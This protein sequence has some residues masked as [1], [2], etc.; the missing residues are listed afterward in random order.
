MFFSDPILAALRNGYTFSGRASRTEFWTFSFFA[1]AILFVVARADMVT[2][3]AL[4]ITNITAFI[5]LVPFLAA[6]SRRLID[7]GLSS[8]LQWLL[9]L[10]ILGWAALALLY[11]LPSRSLT[12][13]GPITTTLRATTPLFPAVN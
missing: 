2:P 5:L 12:G 1:A 4:F 3:G 8:S 13:Y 6:G 7:A 11:T 9:L 10:P